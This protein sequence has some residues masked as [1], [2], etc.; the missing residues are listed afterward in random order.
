MSKNNTTVVIIG[1]IASGKSTAIDI[2]VDCLHYDHIDADD[3]FQT[4]DP[5]AKDYLQD[6]GRWALTNELWLTL[7]RVKMI[8]KHQ[9]ACK[10]KITLID[11]GLLMSWVYTYGHF[12]NKIISK[13]EWKL[14]EEI[15]TELA[16]D[17]IKKCVVI[18]LRYSVPTL[19]KR[20]K[21]R[22]RGYELKFYT[23][24][25]LNQIEDGL[26]ALE[27]KLQTS[28]VPLLIVDEHNV[29]DFEQQTHCRNKFVKSVSEFIGKQYE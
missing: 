5:F 1:N 6:M 28:G 22:G 16:G 27:E 18:R 21:K 2:L 4:S 14:Y 29:A 19:M 20:L 17:A 26:C 7:E 11:S 8:R 25:Y 12:L 23:Q 10:S 13:S 3:L 9:S 24:Q 15:F